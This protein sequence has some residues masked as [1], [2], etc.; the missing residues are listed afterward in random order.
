MFSEIFRF[1]LAYRLK[2]PATYIYFGLLFLMAFLAM[3]AMGGTWGG[4]FVIGGGTGK[5]M[6]NSPYQIN[7]IVTLLSFFG[8]IITCSMM[9]TP[10]FRD[11]EHKTHSL[12]Y[13]API[14]KFGYL[15]GSVPLR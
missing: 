1:E 8:V 15:A 13:T 4:G 9:G 3:L 11:F 2:R 10:I 12:Y 5:V 7:W 14:S 6:A